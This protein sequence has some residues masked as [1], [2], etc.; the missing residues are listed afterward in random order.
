M[1]VCLFLNPGSEK[2]IASVDVESCPSVPCDARH[3][4]FLE[5]RID[6]RDIDQAALECVW[7]LRRAFHKQM[8]LYGGSSDL[9]YYQS[10][11]LAEVRFDEARLYL[12]LGG[13]PTRPPTL[14]SNDILVLSSEISFHCQRN[15][16]LFE[17]R[18][19]V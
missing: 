11:I 10:S 16:L 7:P 9:L 18:C 19:M 14:T 1:A 13:I 17:D 6:L 8:R 2:T 4:Y 15:R 12:S 5:L 3:R